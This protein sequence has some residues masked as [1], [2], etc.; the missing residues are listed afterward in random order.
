MIK[1]FLQQFTKEH[2][3]H[4]IKETFKKSEKENSQNI[5]LIQMNSI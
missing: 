1:T 5:V 3:N 2:Q 4:C